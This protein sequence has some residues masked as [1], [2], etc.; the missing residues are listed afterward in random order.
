V[1]FAAERLKAKYNV[2]IR[3]LKGQSEKKISAPLEKMR[4]KIF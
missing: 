2:K 1:I 4:Q 3:K